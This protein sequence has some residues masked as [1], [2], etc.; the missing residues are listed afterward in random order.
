ML[1]TS[2]RTARTAG[3][4]FHASAVANNTVCVMGAA[5]GIGQPLSLLLKESDHVSDL[6]V[7]DVVNAPGVAA[8]AVTFSDI[9]STRVPDV[10]EAAR[11]ALGRVALG[12]DDGSGGG[13]LEFLRCELAH[14]TA[15]LDRA[16]ADGQRFLY[17]EAGN[18][19]GGDSGGAE[20]LDC[21]PL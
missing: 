11:M 2:L 1:A 20:S 5:G 10:L 17:D 12:I 19:Y 9:A 16:V 15:A 3:R 4:S 14:Q 13:A 21:A 6:R 7:F 18:G 8:D